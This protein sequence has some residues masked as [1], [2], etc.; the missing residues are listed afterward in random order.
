MSNKIE[1]KSCT[2]YT[3]KNLMCTVLGGPAGMGYK[4]LEEVKEQHQEKNK[5]NLQRWVFIS[6][7]SLSQI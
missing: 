4:C 5:E 1:I 3:L 6:S 7:R 2:P